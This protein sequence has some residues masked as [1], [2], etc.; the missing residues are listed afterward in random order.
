MVLLRNCNFRGR[1]RGMSKDMFKIRRKT[2]LKDTPETLHE[3][4]TSLSMH[5]KTRPYLDYSN[6]ISSQY[7]AL[8][9]D[10]FCVFLSFFFFVFFRFCLCYCSFLSFLL[11]REQSFLVHSG[12]CLDRWRLYSTKCSLPGRRMPRTDVSECPTKMLL[13]IR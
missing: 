9:R 11:I 6:T 3:C 12:L 10:F 1:K 5:R 4:H 8:S 7:C 13:S 2:H